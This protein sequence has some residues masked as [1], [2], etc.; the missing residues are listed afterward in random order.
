MV[1]PQWWLDAYGT[2][3]LLTDGEKAAILGQYDG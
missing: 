1:E 3:G 2:D